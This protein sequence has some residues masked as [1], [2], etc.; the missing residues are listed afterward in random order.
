MSFGQSSIKIKK[1]ATTYRK[2]LENKMLI[3]RQKKNQ[4]TKKK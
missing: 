1:K 4:E 2:K 3:L